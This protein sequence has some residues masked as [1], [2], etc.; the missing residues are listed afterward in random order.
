MDMVR[1]MNGLAR[2]DRMEFGPFL[3]FAHALKR[4]SE[5]E[6]SMHIC[7][8]GCGFFLVLG[9][10]VY[11]CVDFRTQVSTNFSVKNDIFLPESVEN[12][13]LCRIYVLSSFA[14][15]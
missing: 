5:T 3:V 4:I 6:K 1:S 10:C 15:T 9:M 14:Y 13:G 2:I 11:K 8:D 7:T 12:L